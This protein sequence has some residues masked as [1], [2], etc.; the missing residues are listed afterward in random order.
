MTTIL[1]AAGKQLTCALGKTN[2]SGRHPTAARGMQERPNP[3]GK[4][5]NAAEFSNTKL[6]VRRHASFL[7]TLYT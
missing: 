5:C 7:L 6:I 2:V 4:T 1:A 3:N